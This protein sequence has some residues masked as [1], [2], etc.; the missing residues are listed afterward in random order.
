M[1]AYNP[2]SSIF[3]NG[4]TFNPDIIEQGDT[5]SG[6]GIGDVTLAGNNT[7][8][9]LNSFTNVAG[10]TTPAINGT[11]IFLDVG[12]TM[13]DVNIGNPTSTTTIKNLTNLEFVDIAIELDVNTIDTGTVS[14]ISIGPVNA[15]QILLGSVG[16]DIPVTIPGTMN[17][18]IDELVV[19]QDSGKKYV[20]VDACYFTNGTGSQATMDTK[21][22]VPLHIAPSIAV[23]PN[24]I[25]TEVVIGNSTIPVT[26]EAT[27]ITLTGNANV[28]TQTPGNSTTL[29]ASTA[30]V[31]NAVSAA[32]GVS[33]SANNVFTGANSFTGGSITMTTQSAANNTTFGATTAFVTGAITTLLA[34]ANTWSGANSFTTGSINV[35]TQTSGNNTTL[36]AST[37]FVTAAITAILSTANTFTANQIFPT[38]QF[39]TG[40]LNQQF[41][42]QHVTAYPFGGVTAGAIV[43]N[44]FSYATLGLTNFTTFICATVSNGSTAAN[45]ARVIFSLS[46]TS[47]SSFT[48]TGMNPTATNTAA[49]AFSIVVYGR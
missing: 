42:I 37:A 25:C 16:N 12:T 9:G 30:F 13:N 28:A 48:V 44:T 6:G 2:P 11:G 49:S 29:A 24:A 3:F 5:I 47:A 21:T 46:A 38:I 36:A 32:V 31:S 1:T 17:V 43:N 7:F 33:L 45:G 40:S 34:A 39:S 35:T 19:D 41:R 26:I 10:I 18:Y 20:A 8:T 4:V 23:E 22:A 15:N 27:T 14:A